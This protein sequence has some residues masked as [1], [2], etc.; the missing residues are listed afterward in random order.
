MILPPYPPIQD[1]ELNQMA[2]RYKLGISERGE[3]YYVDTQTGARN[4][5]SLPTGLY[6]DAY[7]SQAVWEKFIKNGLEYLP[8]PEQ[9]YNPPEMPEEEEEY[10]EED[11]EDEDEEEWEEDEEEWDEEEENWEEEDE[12]EGTDWDDRDWN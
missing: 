10:D 8:T 7:A 11:E 9:G 2:A 3:M 1:Q 5:G 6:P 12:E 4:T